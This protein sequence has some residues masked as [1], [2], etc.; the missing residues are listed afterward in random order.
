VK[1][2]ENIKSGL[3]NILREYLDKRVSDIFLEQSLAI[4]DQS[5]INK[6][7]FTVAANRVSKRIALFIDNSL[8]QTVHDNLVALIGTT[9]SPQGTRRRY[10]RVDFPHQVLVRYNTK[11]YEMSAQNISEGGI[12]ILAEE[13][14]P[15]NAKL[16]ITL[17]FGPG[18]STTVKGIVVTNQSSV[19]NVSKG[20][21]GMGVEFKEIDKVTAKLLCNYV[22]AHYNE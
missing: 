15:V 4:I 10:P 1:S 20:L 13:L 18:Y 7:S 21:K 14:F 16:E 22:E 2:D 17:S 5:A 8:S 6:E 9:A 19:R 12:L 3:K 11:Q